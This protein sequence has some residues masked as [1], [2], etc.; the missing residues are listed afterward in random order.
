MTTEQIRKAFE[1]IEYLCSADQCNDYIGLKMR[2][3]ITIEDVENL[4]KEVASRLDKNASSVYSN[5]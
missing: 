2:A 1:V 5:N 4:Y 3:N